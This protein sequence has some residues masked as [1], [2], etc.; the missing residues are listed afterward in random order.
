[1]SQDNSDTTLLSLHVTQEQ[2]DTIEALFNHNNWNFTEAN[3]TV[4]GRNTNDDND[5]D[6]LAPARGQAF[7]TY[8]L[9]FMFPSVSWMSTHLMTSGLLALHFSRAR[10]SVLNDL[11]HL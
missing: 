2:R 11:P 1:M 8:L 3:D 9:S 5:Y 7:G 6:C 4:P 10:I